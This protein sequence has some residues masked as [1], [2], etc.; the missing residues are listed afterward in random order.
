MSH[1]A[2]GFNLCRYLGLALASVLGSWSPTPGTSAERQRFGTPQPRSDPPL[3]AT[4]FFAG[5]WPPGRQPHRQSCSELASGAK[6]PRFSPFGEWMA[7]VSSAVRSDVPLVRQQSGAIIWLPKQ[8]M[9]ATA[10]DD[11]LLML[12][13]RP[14]AGVSL[15]PP[16][17]AW[18]CPP[19]DAALPVDLYWKDPSG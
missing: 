13:P 2:P 3:S 10:T 1:S 9:V 17:N 4:T 11:G 15:P 12:S 6:T 5:G 14:T 8:G 16:A 18:E 7:L 19:L